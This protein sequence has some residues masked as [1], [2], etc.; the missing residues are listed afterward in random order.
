MLS[1]N[2]Y[3]PVWETK[4][5]IGGGYVLQHAKVRRIEERGGSPIAREG[6]AL[7]VEEDGHDYQEMS[8]IMHLSDVTKNFDEFE[9]DVIK[10][11]GEEML[12]DA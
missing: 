2:K 10:R 7:F 1:M 12:K 8:R 9:K 11:R 5:Y 3:E 4:E 6:E